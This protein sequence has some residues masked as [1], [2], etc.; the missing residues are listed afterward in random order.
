MGV[1]AIGRALY[2][3]EK[4]R[5]PAN[6]AAALYEDVASK[7]PH[8]SPHPLGPTVSFVLERL[9]LNGG[10][11]RILARDGRDVRRFV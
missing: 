7:S 2:W 9:G 11:S 5:W 10:T 1:P 4:D 8:L 3:P 6:A